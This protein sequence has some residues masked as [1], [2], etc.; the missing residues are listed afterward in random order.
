MAHYC[1]RC[2]AWQDYQSSPPRLY[3]LEKFWAFHHYTGLPCDCGLAMDPQLR[4][5]RRGSPGPALLCHQAFTTYGACL[6]CLLDMSVLRCGRQGGIGSEGRA[7]P[8][9]GAGHQVLHPGRLQGDCCPGY[10]GTSCFL[11]LACLH[12]PRLRSKCMP[13]GVTFG[14]GGDMRRSQAAQ[15]EHERTRHQVRTSPVCTV[16]HAAPRHTSVHTA[17]HLFDVTHDHPIMP[18]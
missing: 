8:V 16:L 5:V 13:H 15:P 7:C 9:T 6:R 3:G 14:W 4:R 10:G 17:C 11:L 18:A 2:V 12:T 1:C